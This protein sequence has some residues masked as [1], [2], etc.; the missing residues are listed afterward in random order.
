VNTR[1]THASALVT[2]SRWTLSR[3]DGFRST[4]RHRANTGLS[5]PGSAAVAGITALVTIS[6]ALVGASSPASA[7][8]SLGALAGAGERP[9]ATRLAFT[10]GDSVKAQV[11]V[12][13]GNLLVTVK[14][15]SLPSATL[16][17]YY[18]SA[19][20]SATTV[21][22][23]GKGWGLDY[24]PDVRVV[25]NPDSS[26][27]YTG[28][29]GLTGGFDLVSGST[30]AYVSPPGLKVDLVKTST[31]WTLTDH[32]SQ[33]KLKFDSTGALASREDRN[34]NTTT[35][36]QTYAPSFPSLTI[37]TPVGATEARTARV[38]TTSTKTTITQGNSGILRTVTF[39]KT[40][41]N[42]SSF[43][44][45]LGR[46]TSFTYDS[47]GLLTQIAA[48]GGVTTQIGYDASKRVTSVTQVETATGG[49]G[50]SVT[51]LAYPSS[52]STLLA[53][54]NTSQSSAVSAVPHTTYTLDSTQ[55]VTNVVDAAGRTQ[56]RTYTPNFDTASSTSGTGSGAST[57]TNTF[58]ANN[59]ESPTKIASPAGAS[60]SV[61]YPSAA[62]P[63]QY[64]PT[65][66]TDDA[67]NAS[68]YTYNGAGNQLTSMS[69]G[70]A[71]AKV[72]YNSD[73]TVATATAPANGTNSTTY[74]YTDKQLIQE[75][76]P[77]GTSL[78]ER[79]YTY[80]D[81]GRTATATNGRG[82]TTTYTYDDLD[83]VTAIGFSD[84]TS[85]TYG[86][87]SAGRNNSRVDATG[88]T[89][90]VY[91][92]L[93]RLTSRQNTAGG[94]AIS[95][96]YDKASLLKSST[97]V[98]GGT[99]N[100]TYD[101]A[102]VPA[103]IN[104]PNNGDSGERANL[105]LTVDDQGRRTGSY[106]Q[107]GPDLAGFAAR[108][109]MTYD[110]SGRVSRVTGDSGPS[111]TNYT[112]LVDISYCY[113]SGTTPAGGCT[114]SSTA[115]RSKLQWSKNNVTGVA[116]VY[117]YDTSGRLITGAVAGGTQYDYTYN[118]ND[119]RLTADSQTLTFNPGNQITTSGYTYDGAGNL[120]ADPASAST[121]IQ[122]SASDQLKSVV[123]GGTTYTY[124]HAGTSNVELT[125]QTASDGVYNYAY[126][127]DDAQGIPIL[128]SVNR[129]Y[130]SYTS[131]AA[132]ISDPITGQPVMLRT[133]TGMQSLYIF[134][135][136]PGSPI[137]LINSG[138]SQAFGYDYEPFGTPILTQ[139]GNGN[140]IP[141][142]PYTFAGSGVRDRVTG[143]VH[144]GNRYYSTKTGTFTQQDSLDAPLDPGN[145]NR[146]AYAGN[147]P[148][149]FTDPTGQKLDKCTK[150]AIEAG[151]AGAVG[152]AVVTSETGP[153]ALAGAGIGALTTATA[154]DV[155][156]HVG[157][158]LD[159]F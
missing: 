90:Y 51:R 153:G 132:V 109:L 130:G 112:R 40:Y 82:I 57:T 42:A 127:R 146:Y 70:G 1:T 67:G 45:A 91:D 34:G 107:S 135:G 23:L 13:S 83:R 86:Y 64:L 8:P 133:T 20:A 98:A 115:D 158:L 25:A 93:G 12:G 21:P 79:D 22:R 43:V 143:W 144:Y 97:S 88:T 114:T 9:G 131:K 33:E 18:N 136:T 63:N 122:Y 5:R 87:D 46:T 73:G 154:T 121:S 15:I 101:A 78:G 95:Y 35:V 66:S 55:R 100:Y 19:A 30:T 49:P 53:D 24:T 16:G 134:D 28:P 159:L 129:T 10:A 2:S 6:A 38:A 92:Q 32:N 108:Q 29:G 119:N 124:K 151:A 58:G 102:G 142:N 68:T 152:G 48:P 94:G 65:G 26:V 47:A 44:D 123:K 117:T 3:V 27:T 141:Q 125:Q 84:G 104:Y 145:A 52:T 50:S 149:N 60:N 111:S 147:D 126:G 156:C 4:H 116:T 105:I 138:A 41:N 137:A 118:N 59:G 31:G 89:T 17:A 77:T 69:A 106:L 14:A 11:D 103:K 62:G 54:P 61:S 71:E 72:T 99:V 85:V 155:G 120:T 110:A 150:A 36:S 148:V 81:E 75:T 140:G 113:T 128:E 76:P 80:D 74:S 7:Y 96:T 139:D 157:K 56:S 39:N 37:A